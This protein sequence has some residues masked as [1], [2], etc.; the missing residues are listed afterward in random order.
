VRY[1]SVVY[2]DMYYTDR[3][4]NKYCFYW[5]KL[6]YIDY[7]VC[8]KKESTEICSQIQQYMATLKVYRD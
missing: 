3:T 5:W 1:L 7:R 4:L 2:V 6:E 8:E